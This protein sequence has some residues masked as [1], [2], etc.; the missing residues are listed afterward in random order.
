L[1][2]LPPGRQPV[3]TYLVEPDRRQKW[4]EFVRQQLREG[5]QGYVIVPRVD[6]DDDSD[7]QG[8][9]TAYEALC[10]GEL[11]EFRV[12]L[13][14]GRM[15]YADKHAV[16]RAFRDGRSHI[17][18]ATSVVEI[19]IDVPNATLMTIENAD[20]F[21]LAQLHQVRGRVGR[22]SFPGFV[23]LFAQPQSPEAQA[24]LDAIIQT[25]DGFELADLDLKLRGPGDF[26]G[27]RQHGVPRFRVAR[28]PEDAELLFR[29]REIAERIIA[30]D[31]ELRA[32]EHSGLRRQLVYRYGASMDLGHVG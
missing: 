21:G 28:L 18:L 25:S 2:K 9:A 15:P 13:L 27:T 1:R 19:G 22:G 26:F 11:A 10:H 17:L 24:R 16:M 4:W 5:R 7:I 20:R 32:E 29:A 3:S 6:A 23:G 14:H 12:G 30:G 8:I 31:P